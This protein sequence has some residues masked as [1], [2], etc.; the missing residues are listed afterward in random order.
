MEG[1]MCG[2]LLSEDDIWRYEMGTDNEHKGNQILSSYSGSSRNLCLLFRGFSFYILDI[3]G[4]VRP[5][6]ER[7][8]YV[9]W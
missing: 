7:V 5:V 3:Y 2:S 1:S 8:A 9:A 4:L 6:S